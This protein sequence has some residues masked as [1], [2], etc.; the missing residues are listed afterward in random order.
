MFQCI[1]S[2]SS[3]SRG[4]KKINKETEELGYGLAEGVEAVAQGD[5]DAG[6][7]G[8]QTDGTLERLGVGHGVALL[9]VDQ[10]QV[11]VVSSLGRQRLR[12]Q[13]LRQQRLGRDRL[14]CDFVSRRFRKD[15]DR[16][17]WIPLAHERKKKQSTAELVDFWLK[18]RG[19]N[20]PQHVCGKRKTRGSPTRNVVPNKSMKRR[21]WSPFFSSKN[22]LYR[23]LYSLKQLR[24]QQETTA[25]EHK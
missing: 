5:A 11:V 14:G 6:R 22:C 10:P 18:L 2:S 17:A 13:R 1:R 16:A 7:H 15:K 4:A 19:R 12:Q 9:G 24:K 23:T 20:R 3:T 8:H 21:R 25:S